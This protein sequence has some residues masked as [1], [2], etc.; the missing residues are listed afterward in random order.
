MRELFLR[1]ILSISCTLNILFI[2]YHD[3]NQLREYKERT[4]THTKKQLREII[5]TTHA[6]IPPPKKCL[7][8]FF[9]TRNQFSYLVYIIFVCVSPCLLEY[10]DFL[11]ELKFWPNIHFLGFRMQLLLCQFRLHKAHRLG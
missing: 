7:F 9:S 1:L 8:F 11:Q 6:I 4:P 2:L 5:S 10:L 3:S